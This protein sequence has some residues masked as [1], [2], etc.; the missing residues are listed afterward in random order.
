MSIFRRISVKYQNKI[1][2]TEAFCNELFNKVN[3]ALN[4]MNEFLSSSD[5]ILDYNKGRQIISANEYLVKILNMRD[6]KKLKKAS[7]YQ[8]LTLIKKDFLAKKY[9]FLYEI[10]QHNNRISVQP[11]EIDEQTNRIALQNLDDA[12]KLIGKV[13]GRELDKQQM[14]CIINFTSRSDLNHS[15]IAGDTL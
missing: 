15:V 9:I 1:A 13:E 8:K 7:S 3:H 6:L 14:Q 11:Q 10:K 12:Y 5:G 4:Q 2:Q